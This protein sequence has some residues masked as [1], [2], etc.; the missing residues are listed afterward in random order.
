MFPHNNHPNFKWAIKLE[1]MM[2][3]KGERFFEIYNGHPSVHNYGD[4][5]TMSTEELWDKLLVH[6][7]Q[8]GKPLLYGLATDDAHNHG[9]RRIGLSNPGRGWIMVKARE[10]T[11]TALIK[12]MERGEFYATTGVELQDVIFKNNRLEIWVK[13]AEGIAYTIQFWGAT[14]NEETG[15]GGQLLKEVKGIRGAYKLQKNDL[16]VRAKIISTR[17]KEN[18]Y[19]EG[20]LETAWTQPVQA[21]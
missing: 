6:Y 18:P 11:A 4:S 10:L 1:D 3:L 13:P 14:K 5:T 8:Q 2:E 19:Q 7:I 12:A 9:E 15:K 17:L 20:D 21:N 16:F